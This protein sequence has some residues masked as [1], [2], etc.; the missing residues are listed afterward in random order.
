MSS[1]LPALEAATLG[2]GCFWCLEAVYSELKGVLKVESG[3]AG[4][5]VKNPTY[6]AVCS[7]ETG[8]A[9][10]IQVTYDPAIITYREI[11]QIFFLD[12]RSD[13]SEPAGA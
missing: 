7:D 2:G 10:V 5:H 12:P 11:L 13:D 9:E 8:H 1:N 3:Y 4:G 6:E